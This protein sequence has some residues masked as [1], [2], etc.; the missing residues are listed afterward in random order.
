[1][2]ISIAEAGVIRADQDGSMHAIQEQ[3]KQTGIF[4][5]QEQ[6]FHRV[7]CAEALQL[8]KSIPAGGA[9]TAHADILQGFTERSLI[10]AKQEK[11]FALDSQQQRRLDFLKNE[12]QTTT[13]TA[14]QLREQ[15]S[16]LQIELRGWSL[17]KLYLTGN[18]SAKNTRSAAITG[19]LA[20]IAQQQ[21]SLT[22]EVKGLDAIVD[23]KNKQKNLFPARSE[24][25]SLRYGLTEKGKHTATFIESYGNQIAAISFED[26]EKGC[27]ALEKTIQSYL[28]VFSSTKATLVKVG[29]PEDLATSLA[30]AATLAGKGPEE[31][32]NKA[33][34]VSQILEQSSLPSEEY[35]SLMLALM[36]ES[37]D[38]KERVRYLESLLEVVKSNHEIEDLSVLRK[39]LRLQNSQNSSAAEQVGNLIAAQKQA[40]KICE[41]YDLAQIHSWT[42]ALQAVSSPSVATAVQEIATTYQGLVAA[43]FVSTPELLLVALRLSGKPE[44]RFI[45]FVDNYK[46]LESRFGV[47][48]DLYSSSVL[49]SSVP[50]TPATK[51]LIVEDLAGRLVKL[52]FG[53]DAL[54]KASQLFARTYVQAV[55]EA[56]KNANLE[57]DDPPV[58]SDES[59]QHTVTS[60]VDTG[61]TIADSL[62]VFTPL[63][64][65]YFAE[66][67]SVTEGNS[68]PTDASSDNHTSEDS[69]VDG[70][71]H[72]VDMEDGSLDATDF[73]ECDSLVADLSAEPDA[74]PDAEADSDNDSCDSDDG[75][76]GGGDD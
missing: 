13:E 63:A 25:G 73:S 74:E 16:G 14:Q 56:K 29:F 3:R 10:V 42:I 75:G 49:L 33:V 17:V 62:L 41:Q 32:T 66:H 55:V 76:D 61:D 5:G 57:P 50:G 2:Q 51:V 71:G 37:G 38:V 64:M 31:V 44:K 35:K 68:L 19:E 45:Q 69:A 52:G 1:M 6:D 21:K 18:F 30:F 70:D 26:F 4:C 60:F 22:A 72:E 59:R 46:T 40:L 43:G 15:L 58:G 53:S 39:V 24:D 9:L 23:E 27:I 54:S 12:I 20:S 48:R 65:M 34:H 36:S 28:Q 11:E 67:A 47:S 7:S 8:L